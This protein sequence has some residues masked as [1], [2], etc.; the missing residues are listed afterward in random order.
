MLPAAYHIQK[1]FVITFSKIYDT[2]G[3]SASPFICLCLCICLCICICICICLCIW[4]FVRIWIADIKGFQKI[5]HLRGPWGLAAVLQLIYELRKNCCGTGGRVDGT[6][7]SKVLQEV[8]ADLKRDWKRS[9]LYNQQWI[10]K[11]TFQQSQE[12]QRP[13]SNSSSILA[14]NKNLSYSLSFGPKANI[15]IWFGKQNDFIANVAQS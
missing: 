3:V 2:I 7:K 8:L 14:K 11:T 13:S 5:Y 4:I 10:S 9:T 15:E 6:E 12:V 1:P